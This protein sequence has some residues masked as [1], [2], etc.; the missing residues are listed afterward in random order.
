MNRHVYRIPVFLLVCAGV[1]LAA[2]EV[3]AQQ[4]R[5]E[6]IVTKAVR[7][8]LDI[9]TGKKF[10][11]MRGAPLGF[12]RAIRQRDMQEGDATTV[13]PVS[14]V[15]NRVARI[16]AVRYVVEETAELLDPWGSSSNSRPTRR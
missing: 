13:R 7:V 1:F 6:S 5:R 10:S 16:P 9:V 12:G 14:G 2:P 11:Q 8:P 15:K 4:Q 3:Q